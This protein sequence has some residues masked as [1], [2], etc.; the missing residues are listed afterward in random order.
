MSFKKPIPTPRACYLQKNK[1][2]AY[3]NCGA[4]SDLPFCDGSH[5][6]NNS[7]KEPLLFKVSENKP[8]FLCT[9]GL[10]LDKPYC[11]GSH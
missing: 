11:D 2:Y 7:N 10:S 1:V 6:T 4:S 3:C 8:A 5:K 9:C